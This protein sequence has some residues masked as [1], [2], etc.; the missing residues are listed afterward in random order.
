M[1]I[2]RGIPVSPG[3]VIYP[4]LVLDAED[5]PI[6]RRSIT[7]AQVSSEIARV[8]EAIK[9]AI[10]ETSRTFA[11]PDGQTSLGERTRRIS[12]ASTSGLLRRQ[13][14]RRLTIPF[15]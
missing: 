1:Q 13:A 10:E 12:S 5:Q 15:A 7:D 8:D 14:A 9:D 2:K 3:V 11:C 4:A 6:T